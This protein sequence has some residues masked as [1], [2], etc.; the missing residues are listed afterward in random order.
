MSTE[1]EKRSPESQRGSSGIV[2]GYVLPFLDWLIRLGRP[3]RVNHIAKADL[4][5]W[6]QAE[7]KMRKD[8]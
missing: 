4:S 7:K 3:N 8:T 2:E 6:V 1:Q 5:E